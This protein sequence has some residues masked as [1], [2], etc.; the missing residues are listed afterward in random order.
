[1]L[2]GT[3][4][5]VSVIVTAYK[6]RPYLKLAIDS[7]MNQTASKSSYEIIVVK[8]FLDNWIDSLN[9]LNLKIINLPKT[10]KNLQKYGLM[11]SRGEIISFLDDDDFFN[12]RKI[13]YLLRK[14]SNFPQLGFLHNDIVT[15]DENGKLSINK[16]YYRSVKNEL[17]IKHENKLNYVYKI[18][19]MNGTTNMSSISVRRAI[20]MKI[21]ETPDEWFGLPENLVYYSAMCSKYDILLSEKTLTFFRVYPNSN[22]KPS[23]IDGFKKHLLKLVESSWMMTNLFKNSNCYSFVFTDYKY[24]QMKYQ[25]VSEGRVKMSDSLYILKY[26]LKHPNARFLSFLFIVSFNIITGLSPY[27]LI[28]KRSLGIWS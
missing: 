5:T 6:K 2:N 25:I 23:T 15:V 24:W 4:P 3:K 8:T 26:F 12:E 7:L 18:Q 28:F 11:S 14:F 10:I 9:I 13:E 27:K 16:R 20:A 22:S 17:Y 21:M 19:E 1:M